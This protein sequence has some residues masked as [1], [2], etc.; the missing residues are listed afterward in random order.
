MT[1]FS[2]YV[3]EIPCGSLFRTSEC[4][5]LAVNIRRQSG[6]INVDFT[7]LV[8]QLNMPLSANLYW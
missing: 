7:S 1:P 5:R 8:S 4:R 6:S 2:G 3:G